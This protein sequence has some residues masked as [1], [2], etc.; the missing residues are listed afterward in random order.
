MA[1]ALCSQIYKLISQLLHR[2]KW[3]QNKFCS[4]GPRVK[5]FEER[6]K[7]MCTQKMKN[8]QQRLASSMEGRF[9]E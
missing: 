2:Q 7:G 8:C 9:Y 5:I 6:K 3:Q 4:I 1:L